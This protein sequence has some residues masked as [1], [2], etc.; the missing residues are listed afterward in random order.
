MAF[1]RVPETARIEVVY[2]SNARYI[3]NNFHA[4]LEGGYSDSDLAILA[5]A[6]DAA[7]ETNWL[8]NQADGVYYSKTVVTGLDAEEDTVVEN[9]DG[10]GPGGLG[11]SAELP[12]SITKAITLTSGL[13]GRSARGR[14]YWIGAIHSHLAGDKSLWL[15]AAVDTWVAKVD[16]VR[17]A[18]NAV[19]WLPVIVSRYHSGVKREEAITFEWKDTSY[20]ELYVNTRRDRLLP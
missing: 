9:N 5:G 8:P 10:A 12:D 1:Q 20:Y 3:E 2:L 16:L 13:T 4:R 19:G 6:V 15:Q 7:V 18:I 14:V 11:S 17:V